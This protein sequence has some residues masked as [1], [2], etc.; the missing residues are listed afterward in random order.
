MS[1]LLWK[2]LQEHF[3]M[4]GDPRNQAIAL[5]EGFER[6]NPPELVAQSLPGLAC[7]MDKGGLGG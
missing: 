4:N 5:I 6:A 2:H 7:R 3:G 1:T